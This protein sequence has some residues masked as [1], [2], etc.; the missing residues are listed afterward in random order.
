MPKDRQKFHSMAA[1][2]T[3][4]ALTISLLRTREHVMK[5]IRPLLAELGMTEQKWRILRILAETGPMDQTAIAREACLLLSSVT[6]I[7]TTMEADGHIQR[8]QSDDDRRAKI[9][10]ISDGARDLIMQHRPA[11][12]AVYKKL[13]AELGHERLELL[14]DLLED[15]QSV[16]L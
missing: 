8:V 16:D 10:Q 2:P 15:V 13:S 6:R 4:R 14:L 9:V 5:P 1:A 12:E 7:L 3:S 11:S